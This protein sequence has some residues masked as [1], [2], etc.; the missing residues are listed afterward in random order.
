VRSNITRNVLIIG[1]F[2]SSGG[3][4][5]LSLGPVIS[6][7]GLAVF[8]FSA[9]L[10]NDMVRDLL[11]SAVSRQTPLEAAPGRVPAAAADGIAGQELD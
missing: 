3:L 4:L 6:M 5:A 2:F 9:M 10:V 7:L 8:A 11:L 1:S